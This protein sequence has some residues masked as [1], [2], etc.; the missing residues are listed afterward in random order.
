MKKYDTIDAALSALSSHPAQKNARYIIQCKDD[1]GAFYVISLTSID[2][3]RHLQPKCFA[4]TEFMKVVRELEKKEKATMP[5]KKRALHQAAQEQMALAHWSD[6]TGEAAAA[7]KCIAIL[8]SGGS[9]A[10]AKAALNE[11]APDLGWI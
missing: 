2:F 6:P 4:N 7:Q 10:D 9:V 11:L 8:E 3:L 1:E 5:P